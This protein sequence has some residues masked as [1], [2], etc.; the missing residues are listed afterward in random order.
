MKLVES[1]GCPALDCPESQQITLSHSCCKV[2]K[3]KMA[4]FCK[5]GLCVYVTL[6]GF[7]NREE[8][9]L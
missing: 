2:C 1:A 4:F 6:G 5:E 8:T 3:G 9:F 7:F